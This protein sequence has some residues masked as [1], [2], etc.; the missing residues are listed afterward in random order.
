[1]EGLTITIESKVLDGV[2]YYTL[3]LQV[4]NG[5][6]IRVHLPDGFGPQQ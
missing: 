3:V 5:V 4:G 1:M 2:T 6:A